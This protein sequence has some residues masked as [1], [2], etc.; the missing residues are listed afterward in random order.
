MAAHAADRVRS[1]PGSSSAGSGSD[2]PDR[3]PA[4]ASRRRAPGILRAMRLSKLF[5]TTLRDDPAEAEM[6]SHRLL[7]RAGLRAPAGRR[8]VLAAAARVPGDQARRAGH[9]RGD[10]R[11]RRPG[12]GDA[13]RPPRRAVEGQRPLRQDRAGAGP[14]QG[15][16]RPGHGPGDDP[17]GGR[18]PPAARHRPE[19]SPAARPA[20]PLPDEVPR[21]AALAW[22]PDPR[23][24]VRHEG[25][26]QLRP[27]RRRARR[28]LLGSNTAPTSGSSSASG[29]TRSP[30]APTSGSWAAS[31]AHEFMVLND[32]GE[33]TLVLCDACGYAENQQIAEVAKPDA[34]RRG[35]RSRS[36]TSR[37]PTRRP[38]RPWP[39][40]SGSRGAGPPRPPSS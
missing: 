10:E 12:D 27:R 2:D 4:S 15:P 33:D 5:F 37:P 19:L 16:R 13:R 9:P 35:R 17:R 34:G 24:R 31:G 6:P 7:V 39:R 29:S 32:Y 26:L 14:V 11:D 28:E 21:R 23:P 38:S 30:S 22:R 1:R 36:R 40:S 20:L 3:R 18:R 25:R 8:A